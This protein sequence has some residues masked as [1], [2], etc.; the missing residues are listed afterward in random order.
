MACFLHVV[1]VGSQAFK[2][3]VFSQVQLHLDVVFNSLADKEN[4]EKELK[5]HIAGLKEQ[6]EQCVVF[7]IMSREGE[8]AVLCLVLS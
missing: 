1:F 8:R 2:N 5:C 7:Y 6:S 3:L 4:V